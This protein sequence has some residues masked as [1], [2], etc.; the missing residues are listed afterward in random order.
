MPTTDATR[1]DT[2]GTNTPDLALTTR[3]LDSIATLAEGMSMATRIAIDSLDEATSAVPADRRRIEL[4]LSTL[5]T[6][7]E[8]VA[9]YTATALARMSGDHLDDCRCAPCRNSEA[10]A[11]SISA[12]L[13]AGEDALIAAGALERCQICLD[14]LTPEQMAAHR[15]RLISNGLAPSTDRDAFVAWVVDTPQPVNAVERLVELEAIGGAR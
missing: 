15:H 4:A 9:K 12:M 14:V 6:A 11:L 13:Q 2:P 10:A 3:T 5:D 1:P 7:A 8:I